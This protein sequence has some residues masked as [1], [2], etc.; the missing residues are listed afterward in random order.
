MQPKGM[1]GGPLLDQTYN[2]EFELHNVT[3]SYTVPG[4]M[5]GTQSAD[6]H[7]I[8]NYR[9]EPG[10]FNED[11]FGAKNYLNL[12]AGLWEYYKDKILHKLFPQQIGG[13]EYRLG[14][15]KLSD[16][17]PNQATSAALE[18]YAAEFVNTL[19]EGPEGLNTQTRADFSE[20]SAEELN[21]A[22]GKLSKSFNTVS[23]NNEWLNFSIYTGYPGRKNREYYIAPLNDQFALQL[24]FEATLQGNDPTLNKAVQEEN[25][26]A[27]DVILKSI[28]IDN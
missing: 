15:V 5:W 14:I 24:E 27:M 26:K 17:L 8:I 18:K 22:L 23:L 12:H 13:L 19:L 3:L 20:D 9:Q 6:I 21:E 28:H 25:R 4:G 10:R 1:L 7:Q 11:F 2:I 16:T